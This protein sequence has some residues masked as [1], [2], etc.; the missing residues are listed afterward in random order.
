MG[1]ERRGGRRDERSKILGEIGGFV[2][3]GGGSMGSG[4]IKIFLLTG[5]GDSEHEMSPVLRI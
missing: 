3:R 2:P 1:E 5:S 4:R